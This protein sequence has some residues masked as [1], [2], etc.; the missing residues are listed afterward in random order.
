MSKETEQQIDKSCWY[1]DPFNIDKRVFNQ[2][3]DKVELNSPQSNSDL[4]FFYNLHLKSDNV[5]NGRYVTV[6]PFL[7]ECVVYGHNYRYGHM[8]K[9][10]VVGITEAITRVRV[11]YTKMSPTDD[12]RKYKIK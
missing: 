9:D 5:H 7:Y 6:C 11:D 10:N 2:N 1:V 8:I 12:P 4:E 3:G